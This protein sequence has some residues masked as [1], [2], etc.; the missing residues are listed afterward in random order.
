[1][2]ATIQQN[3]KEVVEEEPFP[4]VLPS[5]TPLV[6]VGNGDQVKNALD[7][8]GDSHLSQQSALLT[9]D[10]VPSPTWKTANSFQAT[11]DNLKYL[12]TTDEV[13]R[14]SVINDNWKIV[15][16]RKSRMVSTL[17]R[18]SVR[19]LVPPFL[20]NHDRISENLFSS[21][22]TIVHTSS[23]TGRL[24][25]YQ[26]RNTGLHNGSLLSRSTVTSLSYNG[27]SG[28]ADF[29]A[30][31]T[32]VRS[33]SVESETLQEKFHQNHRFGATE[34]KK[35]R[36]MSFNDSLDGDDDDND[37]ADDLFSITMRKRRNVPLP[38]FGD[39]DDGE[40]NS[41]GEEVVP[42]ASQWSMKDKGSLSF[43]DNLMELDI[44]KP[45]YMLVPDSLGN[46]TPKVG[47][48]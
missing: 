40:E 42:Y 46:S 20:E 48:L 15:E 38:G 43:Y 6:L 26:E 37:D 1:M 13:V 22:G 2:E 14:Q 21:S 18:Y 10:G 17:P 12:L 3:G 4:S 5:V 30:N 47:D 9:S 11:T 44:K 35:S 34:S 33:T 29:G 27:K 45:L 36:R 32:K 25:S 24:N 39:S 23:S 16:S 19:S 7:I 41:A 8:T 31:A 28:R